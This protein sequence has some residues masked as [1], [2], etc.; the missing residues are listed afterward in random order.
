MLDINALD[1]YYGNVQVLRELS[2]SVNEG[3]VVA[4]IGSN[5]AGK[6]T[7]LRTISGLLQPKAGTITFDGT[8]IDGMAPHLITKCGIG[9]VMEGRQ[10]FANLTVRENL[11]VGAYLHSDKAKIARLVEKAERLFPVLHERR[12]QLGGTLSGGEQQM[13]AIGRALMGSPRMLLLDEPSL[14]LSP[15]LVEQVAEAI[16]TIRDEEGTPML[17]V[18]Q[19]ARLALALSQRGYVIE[20]GE[21][22]LNGESEF[23]REND[24]VKRAYL[25][26]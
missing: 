21:V 22:V 9:H 18:E 17:L 11:L 12:D 2:I 5:G 20:T 24:L 4:V 10:I 23:L 1:V 19:N 3:E 16:E 13:L 15:L 14:G 8:R 26:F 25:G 6:T 7:L